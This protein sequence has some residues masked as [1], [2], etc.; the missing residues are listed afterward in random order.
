MHSAEWYIDWYAN[1]VTRGKKIAGQIGE[2]RA[3][4][5]LTGK[6]LSDFYTFQFHERWL[7]VENYKDITWLHGQFD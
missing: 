5:D 4:P 7:L 2:D 6:E 1:A 3:I